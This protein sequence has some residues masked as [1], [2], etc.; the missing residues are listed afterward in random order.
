[1]YNLNAFHELKQLNEQVNV[2]EIDRKA[3]VSSWLGETKPT[4]TKIAFRLEDIPIYDTSN[5]L[6]TSISVF[7]EKEESW[8]TPYRWKESKSCD[9]PREVPEK[10]NDLAV[11]PYQRDSEE[12]IKEIPP[13]PKETFSMKQIKQKENENQIVYQKNFL[14]N[15]EPLKKFEE[16]EENFIS[17]SKPANKDFDYIKGIPVKPKSSADPIAELKNIVRRS[18]LT[19]EDDPPFNFKGML[20]KTNFERESIK[21]VPEIKVTYELPKKVIS[22]ERVNGGVE[23]GVGKFVRIELGPGIVLTGT[24]VEL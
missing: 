7:T 8:D 11:I 9:L 23:N 22:T 2:D 21:K 10:V 18:S 17:N 15:T 14:K 13:P 5:M 20:R 6:P 12:S 4:V 1:M 19:S 16:P 3:T 24:E